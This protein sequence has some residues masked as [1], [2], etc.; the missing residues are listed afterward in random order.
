MKFFRLQEFLHQLML[1]LINI[2]S[3]DELVKIKKENPTVFRARLNPTETV[4]Y[5][6]IVGL[7]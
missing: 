6:N 1:K 3:S 5:E 2:S 7:Y 4:K